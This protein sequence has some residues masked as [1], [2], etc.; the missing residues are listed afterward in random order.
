M[1]THILVIIEFKIDVY[2]Y[3]HIT[4]GKYWENNIFV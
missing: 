1:N 2:T 4:S 3:I